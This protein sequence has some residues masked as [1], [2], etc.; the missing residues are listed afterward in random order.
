M[1]TAST[2][3]GTR[4]GQT[5]TQLA[6]RVIA[7]WPAGIPSTVPRDFSKVFTSITPQAA[8]TTDMPDQ[9]RLITGYPAR[10]ANM[11]LAGQIGATE[12]QNTQW[13]F[14]AYSST[15]PLAGLDWTGIEGVEFQV[16]Q[17]LDITSPYVGLTVETAFEG[18]TT[19][20]WVA[21]GSPLPAIAASTAQAFAGTHSMRLTWGTAASGAEYAYFVLPTII[22]VTYE[23]TIYA[24]VPA[25]NP[26]VQLVATGLTTITTAVGSSTGVTGRW[27]P[28]VVRFKATDTQYAVAVVTAAAST[29]GNT[30]YFDA[31]AITQNPEVLPQ[32]TGTVDKVSVNRNTGEITFTMIDDRRLISATPTIPNAVGMITP[33]GPGYAFTSLQPGL[34]SLWALDHLLRENG[35]NSSPPPR[36]GAN[37]VFYASMHGSAW[38]D[39]GTVNPDSSSTTIMGSQTYF[40]G[41]FAGQVVAGEQTA[42]EAITDPVSWDSIFDTVTI[43]GFVYTYAAAGT[44]Q[45]ALIIFSDDEDVLETQVNIQ[46]MQNSFG[47][48]F[49]R[50]TAAG[51]NGT[52]ATTQDSSSSTSGAGWH[53]WAVQFMFT[54]A[55]EVQWWAWIDGAAAGQGT[56]AGLAP[57]V[58]VTNLVS[59]TMSTNTGNDLTTYW[60]AIQVNWGEQD[61]SAG[62]IAEANWIPQATLDASLNPLVA[63]PAIDPASDPWG[64]IQ[65]IAEAEFAVAGFDEVNH[66]YF[67]NRQNQPTTSQGIITSKTQIKNLVYEIS[68]ANRARAVIAQVHPMTVQ[69]ATAVWNAQG[70]YG[71]PAGGTNYLIATLDT[72][73]TLIPR[74]FAFIPLGGLGNLLD[75]WS[76]NGYRASTTPDGAGNPIN[77]LLILAEPL[78]PTTVLISIRNPHT[79]SVYLVNPVGW[80]SAGTAQGTPLLT[81]VGLPLT[82]LPSA[83]T[84]LTADGGILVTSS[85]GSAKPAI[86]LG[87]SPWRQ[88]IIAA[89]ALT[90]DTLTDLTGRPR[91]VFSQVTILGDPR[92]QLGDRVTL[93]DLGDTANGQAPATLTEDVIISSINPTIDTQ[94]GFTQDIVCR[95]IGSGPGAWLMGVPGSSEMGVATRL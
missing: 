74:S 18:G 20:G 72:P 3:F 48:I 15:S 2:L 42:T 5:A 89:Q 31:L 6:T 44:E 86:T 26:A 53:A 16:Y 77:D 64:I 33:Y 95:A 92:L 81:I 7:N 91:P 24:Y 41:L 14:D 94:N 45:C 84:A 11:V 19:T 38:P 63:I 40:P 29:S 55:T 71:I 85:T 73:A 79:A 35:I 75:P 78:S 52:T 58:G 57:R 36:A 10:S 90:D 43:S 46:V 87:D 47:N 34:N 21:A 60:E 56:F 22:G 13:L 28:L 80:T 83:D 51:P 82:A 8:L 30:A 67:R 17:G 93:T 50:N 49:T 27:V 76:Q 65:A 54:G 62:V 59:F 61:P 25:S 69:P 9:T 4:L 32:F 1:R 37:C 68:E 12:D 23:V 66:F 70:V 39:I 88:D